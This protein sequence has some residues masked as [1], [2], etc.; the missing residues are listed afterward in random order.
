M[1][2]LRVKRDLVA[3]A[4]VSAIGAAVAISSSSLPFG[5][6]HQMRS[7]FFPVS[8]GI[9][10]ACLGILIAIGSV[11]TKT[12]AVEVGNVVSAPDLRG[13]FAIILSV[14]AFIW[15]GARFGLIPA[16]FLSVLIA[17]AGDKQMTGRGA[18]ALAA[19]LVAVAVGLFSYLLKVPFPLVRW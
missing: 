16:T 18:F 6:L 3:G 11:L 14:V 4:F 10:L 7:G 15:I 12:T 19:A 17:A 1:K 5:T 13:C 2:S 9:L 8:L